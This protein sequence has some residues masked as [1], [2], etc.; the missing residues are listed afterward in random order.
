MT[1]IRFEQ[2]DKLIGYD[3]ES[4]KLFWR[5][6]PQEM[7]KT[8]NLCRFWNDRYAGVEA[9]SS[10]DSNGYRQGAILGRKYRAHRVCWLLLHG[11]WPHGEIDH[12]DGNRE[13][14]CAEN[15][16]DVSRAENQR[17][18]KR[19]RNNTS[20]VNGVR[21]DKRRGKWSAVIRVNGGRKQ[22]GLFLLRSEAV[23][24]RMIANRHHGYSES[25]GVR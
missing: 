19:N 23:A 21:F 12:V 15:L 9:F 14:N 5:Q 17:N 2:V 7:F 1:E 16:R 13:N 6:R 24:A 20:G 22:L 10:C 18:R 4:G 11:E 3:A 25:H 8:E